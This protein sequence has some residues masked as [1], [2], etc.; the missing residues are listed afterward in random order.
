MH[1]RVALVEKHRRTTKAFAL[2]L[3]GCAPFYYSLFAPRSKD[4]RLSIHVPWDWRIRNMRKSRTCTTSETYGPSK[5]DRTWFAFTRSVGRVL[6]KSLLRVRHA[7]GDAF[8]FALAF[9]FNFVGRGC[10]L[11]CPATDSF[12]AKRKTWRSTSCL[13]YTQLLFVH[14]L[15]ALVASW[16]LY[17]GREY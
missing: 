14:A 9:T 6:H 3:C 11:A 8:A 2:S 12:C 5:P 1:F 15:V 13:T 17:Y 7:H 10:I 16:T 4:Y